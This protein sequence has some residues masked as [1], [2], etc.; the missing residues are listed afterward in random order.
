MVTSVNMIMGN[1]AKAS[2]KFIARISSHSYTVLAVLT[3]SF[4]SIH[5][6]ILSSSQVY[7]IDLTDLTTRGISQ[8]FISVTIPVRLML[9]RS[10]SQGFCFDSNAN[11]FYLISA[12]YQPE[13]PGTEKEKE[14]RLLISDLADTQEIISARKESGFSPEK[15]LLASQRCNSG[16]QIEL[17][18]ILSYSRKSQ[19]PAVLFFEPA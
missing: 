13:E 4:F 14:N 7:A 8:S 3:F 1:I 6:Y 17:S 12:A 5:S 15:D 9:E 10:G 2:Y 18:E 16:Q 11:V 19:K